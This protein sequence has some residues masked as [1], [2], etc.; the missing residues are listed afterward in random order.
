MRCKPKTNLWP[1]ITSSFSF[2]W[3][4]NF[5]RGPLLLHM[6]PRLAQVGFSSLIGK[7]SGEPQDGDFL[8]VAN[9]TCIH[10]S[11]L[12]CGSWLSQKVLQSSFSK[13]K[14]WQ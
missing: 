7:H 5:L 2:P 4:G 11:P 8:P 12:D 14:P 6:F 13:L 9:G 3:D 1:P 10:V